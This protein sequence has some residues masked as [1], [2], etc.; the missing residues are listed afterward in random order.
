[1]SV[2]H[3]YLLP[4]TGANSANDGELVDELIDD[5]KDY[6]MVGRLLQLRQAYVKFVGVRPLH[7]SGVVAVPE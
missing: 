1:M 4:I 7:A 6:A 2:T 5:A 3:D